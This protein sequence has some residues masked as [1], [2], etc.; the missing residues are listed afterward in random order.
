MSRVL[1]LFKGTGRIGA[2]FEHIGWEV[3]SVDL[4][5]KFNPTHVANVANFGYKQYAPDYFNFL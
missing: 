5:A 1:E 4:V 3:I 2:A